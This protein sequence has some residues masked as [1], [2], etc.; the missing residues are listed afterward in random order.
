[1]ANAARVHAVERG[2]AV[3][4]H[5]LVAFGG[6]APLHAARLAEKLGIKRIV[7]PADAGVG[8]A[9]GFLRAPA[10]YELVQSRYQRLDVFDAD[11]MSA[12]LDG[13]SAQARTQAEAAAGDRPLFEARQAFMRYAGQ[14]HE[15]AVTLP[16]RP[17][18]AGDVAMMREH[19]EEGYRKLFSRHIPGA[20]IEVL[21][22]AVLVSTEQVQ[23]ARLGNAAAA[24]APEPIGRR[25]VFDGKS[26]RAIDI[27][28]TRA[29]RWRRAPR[30]P[31][32]RLSWKPAP[33]PSSARPSTQRSMP[34]WVSFSSPRSD[35]HVEPEARSSEIEL[36]VMWNA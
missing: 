19:F 32:R 27:P 10:A 33:P 4:D 12:L 6:A 31:G 3:T 2:V 14:G 36:Q 30:S 15:I 34:G 21:S 11:A 25:A 9:V 22:W 24:A 5:T 16:N 1:M 13:M 29:R 35:T 17:L 8:S 7:I 26:A 18:E 28:S 23:P 20:V